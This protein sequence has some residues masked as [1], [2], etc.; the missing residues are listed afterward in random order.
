MRKNGFTLVELIGVIVI[1]A[2]IIGI[3]VSSFNTISKRLKE[4]SYE[5][6]IKYIETIAASYGDDTGD[7]AVFIDTLVKE[8]YLEA[9]NEN[10]EVYDPRDHSL[11]NCFVVEIHYE[12]NNI[13]GVFI[14]DRAVQEDGKTCDTNKMN[15]MNSKLNLFLYE[16]LDENGTSWKNEALPLGE[17]A[18][19]D[20][21]L[22]VNVDD[23]IKDKVTKIV[24]S[25]NVETIYYDVNHDF[26]T[27]NKLFIHVSQIINTYY[28]VQVETNEQ[29]I[30]NKKGTNTY[31][32][33]INVRIDK[34]NPIIYQGESNI[35]KPNEWTNKNKKI[36]IIASDGNGSG[37]NGYY[38]GESRNCNTVEYEKGTNGENTYEIE[39][40]QGTYYVC[41]KDNAGNI[42]EEEST[43]KVTVDKIDNVPPVCKWQGESTVWTNEN[44]TITLIGEDTESGS[45]SEYK[46]EYANGNTKTEELRYTISD[47]AGNTIRCTK[48]V[49]VYVDKIPPTISFSLKEG[50]YKDS[51][52]LVIS[53]NDNIGGSGIK[54]LSYEIYRDGIK[55]EEMTY[56]SNEKTIV[57]N[58]AG[59]YKIRV[60]SL[61][62]AGNY[63]NDN[64]WEEKTYVMN[65]CSY[66]PG[67]VWNFSYRG[68]VQSFKVSCDGLY[69]LT[70]VG[71]SG[72]V[73]STGKNA[74]TGGTT[75]MYVVL[76]KETTLYVAVGGAGIA[77]TG[78]SLNSG[79]PGWNG[80]GF[81]WNGGGGATHFAKT[82]GVLSTVSDANLYCVAGGGGGGGYRYSGGGGGG[83]SGGYDS[84]HEI[85]PGT[86][87]SGCAKGQGCSTSNSGSSGGGG[88]YWGGY[89]QTGRDHQDRGGGGGSGFIKSS[90][91]SYNGKTYTNTTTQGVTG[92][93][94]TVINGSASIQFIEPTD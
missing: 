30:N 7:S 9:D 53:T 33:K 52:N 6:K 43:F 36:K 27:K 83:I 15:S 47:T 21:V 94:T 20:V 51:Q 25:N 45:L 92:G 73:G 89:G 44:R 79:G 23:V 63:S 17:W 66:H 46:R 60:K 56:M 41:V 29:S 37:I 71:A 28:I 11:L 81:G 78:A 57:L 59:T 58:N 84:K 18:K 16:T 10:G 74:G 65:L 55:I 80:G 22:I 1:L 77:G 88:G 93:A 32:S 8:G 24:F 76:E 82:S 91:T 40:N 67:D 19:N 87:T 61:D 69:L 12:S 2:I 64:Q 90:T 26:D 49:N 35:E 72:G 50:T 48:D 68:Y 3:A 14:N 13:Y 75:K 42:S 85:A 38:V 86:Q 5:N 31:S 39:K 34:Q 62:I 4:K 54:E 70:A